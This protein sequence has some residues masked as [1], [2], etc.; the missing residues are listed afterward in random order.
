MTLVH[1][2]GPFLD[3]LKVRFFVTQACEAVGVSRSTVYEWR[4]NDSEFRQAMDEQDARLV[5][6]LRAEAYR[7]AVDGVEEPVTIAG[8]REL[9]RKRSDYLLDRLLRAKDPAF[10]DNL[11]VDIHVNFITMLVGK[12]QDMIQRVIPLKCPHCDAILPVRKEMSHELAQ[13]GTVDV[14]NLMETEAV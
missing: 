12:L 14:V 10:K 3:A 11:R 8:Q 7:R 5:D 13:L 2:K 4:D 6:N 9:I 1:L